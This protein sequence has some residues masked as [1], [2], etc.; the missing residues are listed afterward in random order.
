V[1]KSVPYSPNL[2][3]DKKQA[4]RLL[5]ALRAGDAEAFQ[6]LKAHHPRYRQ[7]TPESF[8]P[9]Q[10]TLADVQLV[11]AREYGAASWTAHQYHVRQQMM[12]KKLFDQAIFAVIEGDAETLKTLL[13]QHPELAN[14]RSPDGRGK[15]TLLQ[16]VAANGVDDEYQKTPANAVEIAEILLQAGADPNA[17]AEFYSGGAGT[18]PL[19]S[20]VTSVHPYRAGVQN[21]LVRVFVA[22]GALVNGIDDDGLPLSNA[23]EHLYPTAF[24]ALVKAGA[25]LDT[26]V[27]AAAAGRTDLVEAMLDAGT[28]KPFVDA[29]GSTVTNTENILGF[30]LVKAC[31]CGQLASVQL[32]HQRGVDLNSRIRHNHT[33]LHEAAWIGALDVVTWLVEHGAYTNALD[34]QFTSTPLRWAKAGGRDAVFAY[35]LPHTRL[36]LADAAEFGLLDRVKLL[37]EAHPEQ[38]N[39]ADDGRLPLHQAVT[40]G[41]IDIV[42]LLLQ[43]GADRSLAD[44]R[45]T[46]ALELARQHNHGEIVSLLET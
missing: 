20:L 37:L 34:A 15:A 26:I 10:L 12:N 33:G 35:L 16:Y 24:E 22:H 32:L 1:V 17:T 28:L 46:T 38:I 39:D 5:K 29:F 13:R 19:I 44:K 18:A 27:Y 7:S 2:E 3:Y 41:Y 40:G 43:H 23:L 42:R 8:H 36:S 30:A 45:G 14:S 25:R 31:L 6:R 4:K 11:I 9:M 21:E